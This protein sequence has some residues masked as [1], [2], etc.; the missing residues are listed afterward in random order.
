M[1]KQSRHLQFRYVMI[2]DIGREGGRSLLKSVHIYHNCALVML[3]HSRLKDFCRPRK[4]CFWCFR[5]ESQFTI[6]KE[7]NVW[8][9]ALALNQASKTC[10]PPKKKSQWG[11]VHMKTCPVTGNLKSS[12][13]AGRLLGRIALR[14]WLD[15]FSYQPSGRPS[16]GFG[17]YT[18][19][20]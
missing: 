11:F 19:D 16:I 7:P 6:F 8:Y 14:T 12:Q 13:P 20:I 9:F 18:C 3:G 4:V 15:R 1:W 5:D 10:F 2:R 17:N